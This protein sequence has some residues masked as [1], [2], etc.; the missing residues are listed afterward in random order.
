M[1]FLLIHIIA[2]SDSPKSRGKALN[3]RQSTIM[4]N[5]LIQKQI[6]LCQQIFQEIC[7]IIRKVS[8]SILY[9]DIQIHV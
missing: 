3:E 8:I 2:I 9:G 6:I 1:L 4:H 7:I 5:W